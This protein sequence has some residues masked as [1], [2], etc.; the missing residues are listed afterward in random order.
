MP[1][2]LVAIGSFPVKLK[3]FFYI[4][5]EH[6]WR[7]NFSFLYPHQN[8]TLGRYIKHQSG[9]PVNIIISLI[10]IISKGVSVQQISTLYHALNLRY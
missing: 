2:F 7:R 6:D 9:V 3:R 1:S 10:V 4:T 5:E 8:S